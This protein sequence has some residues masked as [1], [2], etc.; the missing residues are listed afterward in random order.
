MVHRD[1]IY[2]AIWDVKS[3]ENAANIAYSSL[4]IPPHMDLMYY[5]VPPGY[6]FLHCLVNQ[7]QG[8]ANIFMDTMMVLWV[9]SMRELLTTKLQA[10]GHPD[11]NIVTGCS[12]LETK[13]RRGFSS[14]DHYSY[15]LPLS[16]IG[17]PLNSKVHSFSASMN[18]SNGRHQILL[19]NR[20]SSWTKRPVKFMP[21]A[22]LPLL[23]VSLA[24]Y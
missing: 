9:A 4:P 13:R 6:Q 21:S 3:V 23:K 19:G 7:A 15:H 22:M 8:G 14:V 16:T 5:E 11:P 1:T 2:G 20:S 10:T 12:G 17:S 18:S 24:L